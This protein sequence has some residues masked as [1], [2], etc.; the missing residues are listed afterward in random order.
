MCWPN[1]EVCSSLFGSMW[2]FLT[3][4]ARYAD[5]NAGR[6]FAVDFRRLRP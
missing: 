5:L 6:K 1:Q 3:F 2:A 4:S